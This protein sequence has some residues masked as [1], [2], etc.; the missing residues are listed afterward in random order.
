MVRKIHVQA[1]ETAV[2]GSIGAKQRIEHRRWR[3]SADSQVM[4]AAKLDRGVP[5]VHAHRLPSRAGPVPHL[6]GGETHGRDARLRRRTDPKG[7]R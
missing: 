4:L 3:I 7:R 2:A 1:H 5:H 6:G